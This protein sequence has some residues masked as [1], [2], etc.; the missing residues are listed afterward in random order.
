MACAKCEILEEENRQLRDELYGKGWQVPTEF[1]LT[2]QEGDF[3]A[4]LV[5]HSGSRSHEFILEA[6]CANN[7]EVDSRLSQVIACKVRRKLK[8]WGI[9]IVTEWARGYRL[10]EEHRQRLIHW[11]AKAEAA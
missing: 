9:D 5:A 2:R 3:L 10:E 11:H 1:R 7:A 4:C 6:I 8:P